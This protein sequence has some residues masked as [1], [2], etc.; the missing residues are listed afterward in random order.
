MLEWKS[1]MKRLKEPTGLTGE[2]KFK[3]P[4]YPF[5][6]PKPASSTTASAATKPEGKKWGERPYHKDVRI[7]ESD[8][9]LSFKR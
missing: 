8:M 6:K 2:I 7:E 9:G 3:S 4:S 1:L 5:A